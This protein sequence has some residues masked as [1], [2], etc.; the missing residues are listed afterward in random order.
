MHEARVNNARSTPIAFMN[1]AGISREPMPSTLVKVLTS[2]KL[3]WEARGAQ[4]IVVF[5]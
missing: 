5:G 4:R 3:A 2:R 1:E